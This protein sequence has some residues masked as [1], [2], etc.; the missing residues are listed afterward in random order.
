MVT[1]LARVWLDPC[2][3]WGISLNELFSRRETTECS[4]KKKR[5]R[6]LLSVTCNGSESDRG[7]QVCVRP[8]CERQI[9][10]RPLIYQIS[11]GNAFIIRLPK[12]DTIQD[13]DQTL[14]LH[15]Q[16]FTDS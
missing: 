12:S 8:K 6:M 3:L 13:T 16:S 11:F 5:S 10:E 2:A 15:F 7:P 9:V 14:R 1:H 4:L